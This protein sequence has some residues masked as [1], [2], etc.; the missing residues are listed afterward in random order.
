MPR[1]PQTSA[2][3]R[4]STSGS[5]FS[6]PHSLFWQPGQA[7][8]AYQHN[9]HALYEDEESDEES[10][11]EDVFA[12]LPPGS[13]GQPAPSSSSHV[14][15]A[16]PYVPPPTGSANSLNPPPSRF[17]T[18]KHSLTSI[19]E[20]E[21][22]PGTTSSDL[23]VAQT[24]G[25]EAFRMSRLGLST[26]SSGDTSSREVHVSLPSRGSDMDG[27][28]ASS[29]MGS[30]VLDVPDFDNLKVNFDGAE[31]DIDEDSPYPEVRASVSN[32]DDV[33]MPVLTFRM[34]FLGL[35][36]CIVASGAN[37]FFNFR[38]PS[39]Q[40]VPLVLLLISY[41]AGK[42]MAYTLPLRTWKVP[43]WLGGFEFSLNPGPFNMKEHVL[44]Y[45]MANVSIV[46]AYGMTAIVVAEI[47]YDMKM[48][49]WF[50]L[51]LVMATQLTGFGLAGLCRRFLVWPASMIWP[52]NLVACSLLNTLHAEDDKYSGGITR[53][54]FFM[55]AFTGSFLFFFLPGY[56]FT[57]LSTFSWIC[58]I[59][60]NNVVVNQLFGVQ[61]G[62]GLGLFTFDWSQINWIGS[63]LMVPWWAELHVF[64]G[65]VLFYWIVCP[66]LYYTN[67][68][69]LSYFPM[70]S[71]V[72]YDK[73]GRQYDI[74]RVLG[75]DHR[76]NVTAFEEYSNLYMPAGWVMT[77]FLAFAVS[78]SVIVH[79]A[80]YHGEAL[81]NGVKNMR[82]EKDDVHAKL[83]RSYPEVPDWWYA[84]VLVFFFVLAIVAVERWSVGVP[85]WMLLLS[86]IVSVVYTL[87]G[88]FIFAMTGQG[89]TL[90]QVAQ[91]IPG[92]LL[93]GNAFANM[94]FKVYAIQTQIE[95]IN[96]VQDLKLG[97]YI[98]VPPRATFI[99][100]ASATLVACWVQVSVKTWIFDNVEDICKPNQIDSF[101]C[102]HN[103]VFYT[104]S[105]IWGLIGPSRQFGSSSIYH[106]ELYALAL[107][108]VL[109]IPFWL[110]QRKYPQ[111]RLKYVSIPVVVNGVSQIPPA[112]G[113]NYSSWFIVAF[114]FQFLVRRRRFAWWSK[115]NY[116]LSAALDS[117]SVIAILFI[118]FT[119]Q[120]P[121]GINQP[122]WWG[123]TVFKNTADW[124]RLPL[125]TAP[126][127]GLVD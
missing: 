64:A 75:P 28:R 90:N 19:P 32:I 18:G 16:V 81:L 58:W 15:L 95:A 121:K 112:T 55:I 103:Q 123:T 7:G 116:V 102:P 78:T 82:I 29:D 76:L 118:F 30:S 35:L 36:L 12:Y 3:G 83:M 43:R 60:P 79:T 108:A 62:L 94:I 114:I 73:F 31:S 22:A 21:P 23:H 65:F 109:P 110:W 47:Y 74:D 45:I 119:L 92:S 87:P 25:G 72:P 26:A 4:P 115:F 99:A 120:F 48:G 2:S 17:G 100:Q 85:V 101:T 88:G 117:G 111:S 51:V 52:Q 53:F 104:A 57:A 5:T 56:I 20:D 107:G 59:R 10:D 80:L 6:E 125:R 9:E 50:G 61:S 13:A 66:I 24:V 39:P 106:P 126:V 105:M 49:F 37:I 34:W 11:D 69:N 91:I 68:W 113:I 70:L 46:P 67:V 63:P 89:I 71:N 122:Q 86:L 44:I 41:P 14:H 127:D 38:Q 77:Y 84:I 1:R 124:K 98:K 33:T 27:K 93:P 40:V 8:A 96:F 97:H 42:F 54:K